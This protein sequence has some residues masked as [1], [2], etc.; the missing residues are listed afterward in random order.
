MQFSLRLE[1]QRSPW[2][3]DNV[4]LDHMVTRMAV[5]FRV[6]GRSLDLLLEDVR[7]KGRRRRPWRATRH[8]DGV[9]TPTPQA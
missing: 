4:V 8:V 7:V 1:S 9:I 2:K 6:G 5:V 3:I